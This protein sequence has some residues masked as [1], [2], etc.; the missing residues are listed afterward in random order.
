MLETDLKRLEL[1]CPR[2]GQLCLMD[3]S[4]TFQEGAH[5]ARGQLHRPERAESP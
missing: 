3:F 4:G 5:V 2:R 1:G